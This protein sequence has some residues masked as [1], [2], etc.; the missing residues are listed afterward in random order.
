VRAEWPAWDG[1]LERAQRLRLVD[2]GIDAATWA[3]RAEEPLVLYRWERET[4]QLDVELLPLVE[5][6]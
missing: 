2:C 3:A 5:A 4:N 1:A 6:A